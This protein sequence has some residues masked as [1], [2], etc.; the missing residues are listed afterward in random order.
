MSR[1]VALITGASSGIGAAMSEVLAGAGFD[2]VLVARRQSRLK[3]VAERAEAGGASSEVLALDLADTSGQELLAARAGA[4]DIDVLV[5]NA[6]VSAYGPL[7]D[8]P[9]P[10]LRRAW[11][12]NADLAPLLA[13]V[14][15]PGMLERGRGGI[16]MVASA[17]AFSGGLVSNP[18]EFR[19]PARALY[20]G[21]KAGIVGFGR[22][23]ADE[24]RGTGVHATV[25]CPGM[26]SS[27]WNGGASKVPGAMTPED[28]AAAAWRA[29]VAHDVLCCPGLADG[30]LVDRLVDAESAVFFGNAG[31]RV[32]D[33][34]L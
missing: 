21:A 31:P 3:A 12:L 29:F 13:R 1:P 14:S 4:G 23:L 16:I 22:V 30:A 27:E 15:L 24:L 9:V 8:L 26:V 2:L 18:P 19:L 17:L 5:S 28:V 10:E 25:V 32:A 11:S 33:R 34:Y 20:V 7:V 6:G